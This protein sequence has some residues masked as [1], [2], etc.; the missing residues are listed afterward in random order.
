MFFQTHQTPRRILDA[1]HS[2]EEAVLGIWRSGLARLPSACAL[3]EAWPQ[4]PICGPCFAAECTPALRCPHCALR[5]SEK[6]PGVQDLCSD[7]K[8]TPPP[9]TACHAA[10]SYSRVWSG[11]MHRFKTGDVGLSRLFAA[12]MLAQ[13]PLAHAIA[14][15][16][17]LVPVPSHTQRLLERGYN[18]AQLLSEQLCRYKTHAQLLQR[19]LS[20]QA[21]RGLS[22]QARLVNRSLSFSVSPGAKP[23][24]AGARVLL[25]DDVMTTGATLEAAAQ[26][27]K[28]GGAGPIGALVFAR[29]EKASLQA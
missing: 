7:C 25:V 5:I 18:P 6:A 17:L 2:A 4:G 11:L 12:Q 20:G 29:T 24:L 3:C 19:S 26:A 16:D 21:Q 13:V 1:W 15:A 23:K 27:L 14:N 22:R 10:V 9:W 8:Q 28:D